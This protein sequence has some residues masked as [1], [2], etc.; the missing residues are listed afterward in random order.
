MIYHSIHSD[1]HLWYQILHG[2]QKKTKIH[3]N[4]KFLPIFNG[5]KK[6]H[7]FFANCDIFGL[8]GY[9]PIKTKALKIN[10]STQHKHAEFDKT[11]YADL[12]TIFIKKNMLKT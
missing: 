2:K 7:F 9:K 11:Q 3:P 5:R 4:T 1:D 10:T 12:T 6:K 8:I